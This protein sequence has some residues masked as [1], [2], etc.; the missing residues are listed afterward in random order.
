MS[1]D[2]KKMLKALDEQGFE[3][4]RTQRGH[5]EVRREGRRVATIAG[6]A[7]DHRGIRNALAYLRKAGFI[8]PPR[9]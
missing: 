2:M 9:R 5:F 7:S 3:V 8:W 6:T 1:G 4:T